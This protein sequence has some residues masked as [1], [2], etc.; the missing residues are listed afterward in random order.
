MLLKLWNT[1]Q[2][3]TPLIENLKNPLDAAKNFSTLQFSQFEKFFDMA[4]K[5]VVPVGFRFVGAILILI[6][7]FYVARKVSNFTSDMSVRARLDRTLSMTLGSVSRYAVIAFTLMAVMNYCGVDTTSLIAVLGAAGLAVGLA[8]QGTLA[9]V[10]AGVMLLFLRPFNVGN[11]IR[12]GAGIEGKV[13]R[14]DLFAIEMVTADN[15]FMS[16]PNSSVWG[17]TITNFSRN[18]SRL[19]NVTV[20]LVPSIDI[21]QVLALFQDILNA[22]TRLL[23][24]SDKAVVIKKIAI[25]AIDITVKGMSKNE[26]WANVTSD[27]HR[28]LKKAVEGYQAAALTS[29]QS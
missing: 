21:D 28:A 16:V 2:E 12:V 3:A 10:A 14:I 19:V 4:M 11:T 18:P 24:T 26:D 23:P 7:G 6:I 15:L 29:I 5:W 22:E 20:S 9:N 27:L 25:D 13:Q 8:L 17:A 1:A